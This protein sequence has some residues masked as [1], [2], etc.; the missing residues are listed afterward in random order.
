MPDY[1]KM[2]LD[3]FNSVTDVIELLSRMRRKLHIPG[4]AGGIRER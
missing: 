4:R 2:Y 1:Q 3:L